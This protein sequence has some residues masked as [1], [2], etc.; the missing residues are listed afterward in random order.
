MIHLYNAGSQEKPYQEGLYFIG[1]TTK[2]MLFK[3]LKIVFITALLFLGHQGVSQQYYI[4]HDRENSILYLMNS[5]DNSASDSVM[6]SSAYSGFSYTL[7][8]DKLYM[9]SEAVWT[10]NQRMLFLNFYQIKDNRLK[11]RGSLQIIENDRR[12]ADR[13]K[14]EVKDSLFFITFN[15]GD[16]K[17]VRNYPLTFKLKKSFNKM[18]ALFKTELLC[19]L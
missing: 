14:F 9:V 11:V 18:Y 7:Y 4:K 10:G 15:A 5:R 6:Y 13:L 8:Q 16:K 1:K 12:I 2:L 3:G 17:V 19:V